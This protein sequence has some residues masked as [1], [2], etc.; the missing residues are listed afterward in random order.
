VTRDSRTRA[1]VEWLVV[2]A[3]VAVVYAFVPL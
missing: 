3:V 1:M 2:A